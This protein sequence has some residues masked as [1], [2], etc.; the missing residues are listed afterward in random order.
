M[1]KYLPVFRIRLIY[2]VQYRV[3]FADEEVEWSI[4]S[5]SIAYDLI[6]PADLYWRWFSRSCASRAAVILTVVFYP[7]I[8]VFPIWLE[9]T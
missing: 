5:G 3:V 1:T 8:C 4:E 7:R 6:R 2:G 9:T